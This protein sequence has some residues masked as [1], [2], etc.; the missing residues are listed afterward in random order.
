MKSFI[1]ACC[2]LL[3]MGAASAQPAHYTVANAHSHNDY[4]QQTPYWL[5]YNAGFGS[6]EADIFLQ[7]GE[8]LVG[9]TA[10]ELKKDRTLQSL[11]LDPIRSCIKKHHGFIFEDTARKMELLIDIKTAAT[12]TLQKLVEVLRSYPLLTEN[13]SLRFVISGNRP[14]E[15]LFTTYPS[16]IWFDAELYK[17]YSKQALTKIV[18]MSDD[19]R[20]Y[21]HWDGKGEIPAQDRA[22]L[23]QAIRKSH[24]Q[25]Q[26]VRFWDAPDSKNAWQQFMQLG[27]DYINTDHIRELA[28]FLESI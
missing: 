14:D 13:T 4:E 21:S 8:L 23:Q 9:H 11:Y 18:L 6:T 1:L 17:T 16:F 25:H 10:A 22:T 15:S 2:C 3:W 12:A 20:R 24:E 28:S 19:F 26:P 27:V 7:D 5:A